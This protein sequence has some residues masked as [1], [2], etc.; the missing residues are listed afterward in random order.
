MDPVAS[1]ES[2]ALTV[3]IDFK[4]PQAYLALP[5]TLALA[6]ALGLTINWLP[7]IVAPIEQPT[8]AAADDSRGLR[9]RR[10]RAEYVAKD[11]ARYA[12]VYGLVLEDLYR[13][14]DVTAAAVGLLWARRSGEQA[15][16]RYVESV[17]SGH[18]QTTLDIE[19][20]REL[21]AVLAACDAAPDGFEAFAEREGLSQLG[22]LQAA[23]AERGVVGVPA[24]LVAE[25]CFVGRAHL[26]M[27]RRLL[28]ALEA[29]PT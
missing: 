23:L 16:Q 7:R 27:I 15:A 11:I 20:R 8:V 13:R 9:H 2:Q 28:D 14:P 6:D 3:C 1:L 4:H 29:R 22:A 24:Y 17:F 12:K 18:W 10:F 26:P 21:S 5:P 25:Q 19:N